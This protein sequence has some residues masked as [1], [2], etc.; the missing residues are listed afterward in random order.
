MAAHR[1][2]MEFQDDNITSHTAGRTK[3]YLQEYIIHVTLHLIFF[4]FHLYLEMIMVMNN[5]V[6]YTS[7]AVLGTLWN[8]VFLEY[9]DKWLF[10]SIQHD[11]NGIGK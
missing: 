4:F 11:G 3:Q 2:I 9:E 5:C 8:I 10:T 7:K 1:H 6:S